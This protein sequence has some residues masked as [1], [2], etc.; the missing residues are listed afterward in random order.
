MGWALLAILPLMVLVILL[1]EP[2]GTLGR[3]MTWVPFTSPLTIIIRL[4]V[5]SQ[6]IGWWEVI[7]AVVVLLI[8]IW[9]AIRIGARLFRVGLLLTGSRPSLAELWRQAR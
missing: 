5:D 9:A 3:A 4:A 7:G 8:S 1:D 6:G 2:N